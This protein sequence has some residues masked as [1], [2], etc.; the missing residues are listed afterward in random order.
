MAMTTTTSTSAGAILP[1][2]S[3][4]LDRRVLSTRIDSEYSEYYV[5]DY[6]D[7]GFGVMADFTHE[8]GLSLLVGARYDSIDMEVMTPEGKTQVRRGVYINGRG[9]RCAG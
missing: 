4:A 7:L 1:G 8:S 3:T 9:C 2:P 5:G 6:T